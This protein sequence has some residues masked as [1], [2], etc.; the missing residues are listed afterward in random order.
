MKKKIA[1]FTFAILCMSVFSMQAGIRIG[2][3]AGVNLAS[4]SL[5][6]IKNLKMDNLT[7]FQLGPMIELSGLGLGFDA[8]ILYS[9]Y[10]MKIPVDVNVTDPANPKFNFKNET[11]SSILVPVNLKMKFSLMGMLGAYVAAGPYVNFKVSSPSD[12][13][14]QWDAQS[15]GA[16]VNVGLGVELIK[17]V[18][19]GINYQIP[20]TDDY[21]KI[22]WLN[23]VGGVVNGKGRTKILSITAAYFF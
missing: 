23:E 3:K 4:T 21:S 14:K 9:Q 11:L 5:S 7:G 2:V 19:V 12:I 20:V 17:H 15:F 22:S 8:A 18:Q 10:G 13:L 16:G 6:E 1:L